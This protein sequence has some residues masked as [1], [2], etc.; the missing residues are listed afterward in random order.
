M[1]ELYHNVYRA[2]ACLYSLIKKGFAESMAS[3]SRRGTCG[4]SYRRV[5]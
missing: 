1:Q 4:L 3:E 2:Y 5:V